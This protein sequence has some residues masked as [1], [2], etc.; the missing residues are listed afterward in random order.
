MQVT[1][2]DDIFRV[3]L[4]WLGPPGYTLPVQFTYA[5]IGVGV[6]ISFVTILA[7]LALFGTFKVVIPAIALGIFLTGGIWQ[8]V[9]PDQPARKVIK[10]LVRDARRMRATPHGQ[11][12]RFTTSHIV[13]R[14]S[15]TAGDAVRPRP[16]I[17][18]GGTNR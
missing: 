11:T 1:P 15:T 6:L 7:G 14:D 10:M 4:K 3:R 8:F 12:R 18:D 2:D 13:V 5:Q 17:T 16:A 9:D